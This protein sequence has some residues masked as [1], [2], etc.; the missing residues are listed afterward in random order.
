MC[1]DDADIYLYTW[2]HARA[3]EMSLE[4]IENILLVSTQGYMHGVG[5]RK[6]PGCIYYVP[7]FPR[8]KHNMF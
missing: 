4:L 2:G 8:G 7:S 1:L 3:V 5:V 6:C